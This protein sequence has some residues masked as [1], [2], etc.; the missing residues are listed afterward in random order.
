M[1]YTARQQRFLSLPS[2]PDANKCYN[3]LGRVEWCEGKSVIV[4]IAAILAS[5]EA[6]SLAVRFL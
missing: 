3:R 4:V 1:S 5:V 2:S 6:S